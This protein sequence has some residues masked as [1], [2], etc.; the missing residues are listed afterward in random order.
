MG[1]TVFALGQKIGFG[2]ENS[3]LFYHVYPIHIQATK[4]DPR[5]DKLLQGSFLRFLDDSITTPTLIKVTYLAAS[6]LI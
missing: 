6:H 3:D 5:E 4:I 2:L 1:Q